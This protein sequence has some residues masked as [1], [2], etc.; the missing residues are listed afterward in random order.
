MEQDTL[1]A[2]PPA[3]EVTSAEREQAALYLAATRDRLIES[4]KGLSEAQWNFKPSPDRWSI[5]E[6]MEH[7]AIGE[8][9]IGEIV[10]KM[11]DA[12]V[13]STDRDAKRVDA[14]VLADI[15]NRYPRFQAPPRVGPSGRWAGPEAAEQFLRNRAQTAELLSSS[16]YL[17][18]RVVPH[19]VFGPWDGYEWILAAGG[20]CTR[21]TGQIFEVKAH[22]NFP[23]V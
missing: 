23:S 4:L 18:G 3:G 9:R 16:A 1:T 7:L 15:P 13:A 12:P 21:H 19:P 8:E 14:F 22:P 20:H 11:A 2:S 5:A 10:G 17:R 6:I